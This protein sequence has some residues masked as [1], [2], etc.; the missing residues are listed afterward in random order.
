MSYRVVYATP[1]EVPDLAENEGCCCKSLNTI[2]I[3]AGMPPSRMRDTLVH[4]V[5]HAFLEASGIGSFLA[6]ASNLKGDGYDVFE[7]TFVRLVTPS[8]IRLIS[9]NGDALIEI[10]DSVT[11]GPQKPSVKATLIGRGKRSR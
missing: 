2:Y 3:R 9:D 8:V 4:E 6:S 1:E 10:P 5:L 7:E 11:S